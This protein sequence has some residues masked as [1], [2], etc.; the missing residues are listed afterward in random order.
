VVGYTPQMTVGAWMGNNDN[1]PIAKQVA[2]YIV[3][4][5]WHEYMNELL[6]T[7]PDQK[8]DKPEDKDLSQMKPVLRGAW[9][10][11]TGSA[12]SILYYVD[13]DNPTGP[14]PTNPSLDPQFSHWEYAVQKWAGEN[15][16]A[17]GGQAQGSLNTGN[18]SVSVSFSSPQNGVTYTN[19]NRMDL[20]IITSS[21]NPITKADYFLQGAYLGT[22]QYPPYGFSFTLDDTKGVVGTNTIRV[23]VTDSTGSQNAAS[24]SFVKQ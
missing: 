12:H 1:T 10:D 13:K 4:P 23:V 19:G 16:Y 18:G 11:T 20:S 15:G 21:T 7:L 8:F 9:Q 6:A 22:S 2:G 14:V 24:L 17:L 5:M 3:A